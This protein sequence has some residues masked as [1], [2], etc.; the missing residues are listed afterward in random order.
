[1]YLLDVNGEEM[2]SMKDGTLSDKHKPDVGTLP[3]GSNVDDQSKVDSVVSTDLVDEQKLET[4]RL[5]H[6]EI[7][8]T[9]PTDDNA[10]LKHDTPNDVIAETKVTLLSPQSKSADGDADVSEIKLKDVAE[11]NAISSSSSS[12]CRRLC[13]GLSRLVAGWRTYARQSVVF[14]GL[15]LALLYMT[16]L[17]F[18]SITVGLFV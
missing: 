14:A 2:V 17:G 18:D 6:G 3:T 1:M 15:S 12:V 4:D 9:R 8:T 5:N 7:S 16:V 10:E 13:N 11:T